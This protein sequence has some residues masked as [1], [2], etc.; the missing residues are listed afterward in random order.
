LQV[1][2]PAGDELRLLEEFKSD[3]SELMFHLE[4][5]RRNGRVFVS[6]LP[7]LRFESPD[8]FK[9]LSAKIERVGGQISD[10]HTFVLDA[11]GWKKTDA[12]QAEFKQTADPF[13]L[14]NPGKLAPIITTQP[15]L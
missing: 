5:Q 1:R 14:M 9:T 3:F 13:G 12:P 8:A 15:T 11:A 6:S 10:A 7:L 4:F 2:F